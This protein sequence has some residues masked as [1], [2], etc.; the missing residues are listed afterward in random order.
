MWR[1]G[2]RRETNCVDLTDEL[3]ASST[4]FQVKY[5]LVLVSFWINYAE[6]RSGI[7]KSITKRKYQA[8]HR[9]MF[10]SRYA[11]VHYFTFCTNKSEYLLGC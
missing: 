7:I 9:Y 2:W 5:I 3:T 11:L 8:L 10:L 1:Q 6:L 4:E